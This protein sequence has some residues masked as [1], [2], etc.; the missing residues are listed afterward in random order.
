[1]TSNHGSVEPA[2]ASEPKAQHDDL[3]DWLHG[4]RAG[5]TDNSPDWLATA[6]TGD[7]AE[8]TLDGTAPAAFDN[9]DTD[10]QSRSAQ[11]IGRHRAED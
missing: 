10:G 2:D 6:D 7:S 11:T 4:I 9:D 8:A 5:L 3:E 1:M